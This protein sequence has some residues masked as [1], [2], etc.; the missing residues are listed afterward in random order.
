MASSRFSA[1][2]L[3]FGLIW[4]D[5]KLL[6]ANFFHWNLSKIA[7]MLFAIV[8]GLLLSLPF[9]AGIVLIGY[10]ILGSASADALSNFVNSGILDPSLLSTLTE[11]IWK[12]LSAVICFAVVI[13]IFSFTLTYTYVLMLNVYRGYLEG[14]K[15]PVRKNLYFSWQ[16]L[17]KY[18]G[19]LGWTSLYILPPIVFAI[20][21]LLGLFGLTTT[22]ILDPTSDRTHATIL[23][24]LAFV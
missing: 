8:F 16:H 3:S 4:H 12:I 11:N 19:V 2:K 21:V 15:L 7:I 17:K 22:G 9:I 10:S 1:Y 6:Y 20:I 18:L 13:G 23:G 24:S 14:K 5:F